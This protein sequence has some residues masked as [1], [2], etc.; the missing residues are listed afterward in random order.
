MR[1]NPGV[2]K[3]L[4]LFNIAING[5]DDGVE[6]T[7]SKFANDVKLYPKPLQAD[8]ELPNIPSRNRKLNRSYTEM[9]ESL[10]SSSCKKPDKIA[11]DGR[12]EERRGEERRGE[13]RRGEERR[14]E[15]RRGEER[16][17]QQEKYP[18]L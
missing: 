18:Q 13:E 2:I 6:C 15:E 9:E 12:G 4:I 17:S 3:S 8:E 1:Y 14:G 11:K 10:L 16:R 7:L 5:L